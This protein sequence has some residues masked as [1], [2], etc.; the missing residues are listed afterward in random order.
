MWT[1]TLAP[2]ESSTCRSTALD[3]SL[4]SHWDR[5][6]RLPHR[7]W[8]HDRPWMADFLRAQVRLKIPGIVEAT[9]NSRRNYSPLSF[10]SWG[11]TTAYNGDL[12]IPTP[13]IGV[14]RRPKARKSRIKV[15][16]RAANAGNIVVA[17]TDGASA[18]DL[19]IPQPLGRSAVMSVLG[20]SIRAFHCV[21]H[22]LTLRCSTITDRTTIERHGWGQCTTPSMIPEVGPEFPPHFLWSA[23]LP[24]WWWLG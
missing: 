11:R 13:A 5:P 20:E 6:W 18:L 24:W 16:T 15:P 3:L 9:T 14:P 8:R 23:P 2:P 22:R 1:S 7:R 19:V 4:C 12:A 21:A 10:S 17:L